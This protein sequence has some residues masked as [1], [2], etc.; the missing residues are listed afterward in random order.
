MDVRERYQQ[1][2]EAARDGRHEEALREYLWFHEHALE[3]EP[4]MYEVRLGLR[5]LRAGLE[6]R[7]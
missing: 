5:K 6:V 7:P 3:H 1:A 4:A 2:Q